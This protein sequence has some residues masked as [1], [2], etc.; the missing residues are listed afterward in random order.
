MAEPVSLAHDRNNNVGMGLL[1]ITA[2]TLD[3]IGFL[4]LGHVFASAMTG[5]TALLGIAVGGGRIL[6]ASQPF[7]ALLGFVAGA[8]LASMVDR[9]DEPSSRQ[10]T[11]LRTLLLAEIVCLAGFAILWQMIDHPS[12][13]LAHYILILLCSFAMG[14]Q[15]IAAKTINAPG[16]NTI[17]F[18]STVVSIVSSVT[19]ILLGRT[20]NVALK[21]ATRHQIAVFCAYGMG[22]LV[23]GFLEWA[24]FSLLVY[25]PV[26]AVSLALA[27]FEISFRRFG[28]ER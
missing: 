15:G 4:M 10:T 13:G 12:G 1:A 25:M 3:V 26:A 28:R 14:V 21:R 18:T 24:D 20:K 17:V 23:A 27:S 16:V 9:P 5:N 8:A 7:T 6:E 2:G 22:V 19:Q 11:T